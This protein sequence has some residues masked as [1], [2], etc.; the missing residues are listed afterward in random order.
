VVS[1]SSVEDP[2][3]ACII[4]LSITL[5]EDLGLSHRIPPGPTTASRSQWTAT[6][7]HAT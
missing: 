2:T 1:S 5:D 7:H 3:A 4:G 6:T